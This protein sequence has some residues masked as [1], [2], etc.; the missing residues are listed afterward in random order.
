M[1]NLRRQIKAGLKGYHQRVKVHRARRTPGAAAEGSE[2]A[3][4]KEVVTSQIPGIEVMDLEDAVKG[5][6]ESRYLC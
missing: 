4:P 3:S 5:A 1:K 6:V 2:D